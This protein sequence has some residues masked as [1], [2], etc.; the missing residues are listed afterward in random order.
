[1]PSLFFNKEIISF[2]TQFPQL[3]TTIFTFVSKLSSTLSPKAQANAVKVIKSIYQLLIVAV[4]KFLELY[5]I[6]MSKTQS[7]TDWE[8]PSS[9]ILYPISSFI[10]F[11][12]PIKYTINDLKD[13]YKNKTILFVNNRHVYGIEVIPLL[14]LIYCQTGIWARVETE[15]FC[16]IL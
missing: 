5:D 14:A 6:I 11:I 12:V 1:M 16:K 8:Q 9:W 7:L 3:A 2:A 13:S 10:L 15:S 4:R